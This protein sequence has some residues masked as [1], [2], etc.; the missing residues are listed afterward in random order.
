VLSFF[1]ESAAAVG[2]ELS[3]G[4]VPL[5][6]LAEEYGTPAYVFD[7]GVGTIMVDNA[8]E[9][10]R[11]EKLMTSTQRVMLRVIP[12]VAPETHRTQSTGGS[13]S[14]FGVPFDQALLL[15]E[16]IG[17]N[18]KLELFGV[19]L[20]TGSQMLDTAPFAAAVERLGAVGT[21]AAYDIGGGLGVRYTYTDQAPSIDAYL[22][23]IVEVARRVLPADAHLLIEPGRSLVARAGISLYRVVSVKRTGRTFVAVDGGMA[24]NIDAA[25]TGQRYEATIA[26]RAA[27]PMTDFVD[28][29]GRH[30]ESGDCLIGGVWLPSSQVDDLLAIATTGAYSYTMANNYNGALKEPVVLVEDGAAKARRTPRPTK[31][32]CAPMSLT[33]GSSPGRRRCSRGRSGARTA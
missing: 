16:R 2:G 29:V 32:C 10:D 8:D 14:K 1:P 13:D 30:C 11:L 26:N 23:A 18:P 31:I 9:L 20:H 7:A 3:I 15:I 4:G 19:H 12:D 22:D 5:Q 33:R 6:M 27:S 17:T 25:Y 24:D 28:V 21:F